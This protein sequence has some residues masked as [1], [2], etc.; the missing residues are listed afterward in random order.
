MRTISI[1]LTAFLLGGLACGNHPAE[2]K[3][4]PTQAPATQT[5]APTVPTD[6]LLGKFLPAEHPDFVAV[7]KPYSDKPGMYLRKETFEAF[8]KM[9]EAAQKDKISLKIISATRN[10]QQQK[11]IWE[12]KWT[13]FAKEAPGAEQRALK[14]L[15]YSAMP[16]TSRHH[17][18]TDVDLND[19]N[20]PAFKGGGKYAGTYE[21]LVKNA[22]LYGFCQPYTAKGP[23]RPSGY[24]EERWH[25]SY[26]PL[27]GDFLTQYLQT[28]QN[29]MITGFK[30]S[31]T[32]LKIGAVEH[33]AA[34]INKSCKE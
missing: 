21:W 3:V 5:S 16:G 23:E 6:Y 20:N 4:A 17:W 7:S 19:L 27:S 24:E 13:R 14:I 28:I 26:M 9:F 12:G 33:Y 18:G 2:Q 31:E 30:G 10:F 8:Q 34:G 29:E 1:V 22:H 32:A 15:E 25:W 11:Q